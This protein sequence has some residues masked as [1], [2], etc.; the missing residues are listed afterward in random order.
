EKIQQRAISSK[1]DATAGSGKIERS[2]LHRSVQQL[3]VAGDLWMLQRSGKR[4][5]SAQYTV[6]ENFRM[7]KFGRGC[8]D[9]GREIE[10][11]VERRYQESI[12]IRS[13]TQGEIGRE[14]KQA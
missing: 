13:D 8:E 14:I 9:D 1:G 10:R 6:T 5:V 2:V 11:H 7:K 4:N 12:P 3:Y